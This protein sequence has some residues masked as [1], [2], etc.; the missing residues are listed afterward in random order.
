MTLVLSKDYVQLMPIHQGKVQPQHMIS[1]RT[2]PDVEEI[3]VCGFRPRATHVPGGVDQE[4]PMNLERLNALKVALRNLNSVTEEDL[5]GEELAG[6][7]PARIFRSFVCP[8]PSA[9]D[10][11]TADT[12]EYIQVHKPLL[13]PLERAATRTAMQIEQAM[14]QV[15]A[16]RAQY[17]RNTDN[18]M[19][20]SESISLSVSTVSK[21]LNPV[22][23]VLDN[24]RSAH[25]V[26]SIF[27]TADTAGAVGLISLGMFHFS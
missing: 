11:A 21:T 1:V 25:N 9:E 15:R 6:T 2:S 19:S 20:F 8:R 22:V 17:L 13:G 24:L 3:L 10:I 7:P 23:I 16:D 12:E 26:G 27:R 14:R 5:L 4:R 18:P